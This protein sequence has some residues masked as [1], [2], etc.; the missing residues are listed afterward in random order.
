M[1]LEDRDRYDT[2]GIY[3]ICE[4][5]YFAEETELEEDETDTYAYAGTDED[6]NAL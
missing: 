6:E 5:D 1:V 3:D 4:D 2:D